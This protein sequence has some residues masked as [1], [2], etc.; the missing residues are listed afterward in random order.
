MGF[1]VAVINRKRQ[2]MG[3]GGCGVFN[4]S[5]LELCQTFM[6][7]YIWNKFCFVYVMHNICFVNFRFKSWWS[8]Y[9]Q[10]KGLCRGYILGKKC[11]R[12]YNFYIGI[13]LFFYNWNFINFFYYYIF[14]LFVMGIF[15]VEEKAS[16]CVSMCGIH[17]RILHLKW[18]EVL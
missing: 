16:H 15:A 4:K 5:V 2:H 13:Y 6:M 12:F 11:A 9:G 18:A 1:V 3:N 8:R 7:S 14:A 17:I 10:M